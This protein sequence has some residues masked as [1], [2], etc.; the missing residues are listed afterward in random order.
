[1]PTQILEET[2]NGV[3]WVQPCHLVKMY[4]L[5]RTTIYRHMQKMRLQQKYKD[6]IRRVT[7]VST[8]VNLKDFDK[9]L[10]E[11]SKIIERSL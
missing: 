2:I 7:K 3:K 11:Q 4:G 1:M 9:Y 8:L 5:S 10:S 6:S